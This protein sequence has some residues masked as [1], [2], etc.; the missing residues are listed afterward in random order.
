MNTLTSFKHEGVRFTRTSEGTFAD[1]VLIRADMG[2][3]SDN[4][5][6]RRWAKRAYRHDQWKKSMD[7]GKAAALQ[8]LADRENAKWASLD[9]EEKG[10]MV[11]AA[12]IQRKLDAWEESRAVGLVSSLP[13]TVRTH[14][15]LTKAGILEISDLAAKTDLELLKLPDMGRKSLLEVRDAIAAL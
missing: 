8:Q 10:I 14:N 6:W 15:A 5:T 9:E 4:D 12:A 2:M 7:A 3:D 11:K 1:G 13:L